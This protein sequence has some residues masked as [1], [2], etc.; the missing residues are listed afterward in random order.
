MLIITIPTLLGC[1]LILGVT[2]FL[3]SRQAKTLRAALQN[4]ERLKQEIDL[5]EQKKQ[6]IAD[7]I[8]ATS[9]IIQ[10]LSEMVQEKQGEI[11]ELIHTLESL[12]DKRCAAVELVEKDLEL[13]R[14]K[15]LSTFEENLAEEIKKKIAESDL[16]KLEESFSTLTNAIEDSKK[17]LNIFQEQLKIANESEDFDN[18]HSITLSAQEKN[19]ISLIRDFSKNFFRVE[20]LNKLI[21]TEYYQKPLQSLRKTLNADKTVGIY[22][23][24]NKNNK[25]MYVGQATC[26]GTRWA[27]HVKISLGIG[28]NSY[29]TNKFYKAMATEG[30]ENFTF[31]VLEVCELSELNNSEKYW[32]T[33]L[34]AVAFGY[35]SKD[36]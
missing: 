31:E 11:G 15:R 23:I 34:N 29:L 10:K 28:S 16:P 21:W 4:F 19:D 1:S 7:E 36:N 17:K 25:K 22:K 20:A 26:I 2:I 5:Q 35:N 27:E 8:E 18:F 6:T 12:N 32:I 9:A 3:L 24:T 30:A 13:E 14:Q 33:N